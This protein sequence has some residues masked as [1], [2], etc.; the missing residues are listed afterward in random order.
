V[1]RKHQARISAAQQL[2]ATSHQTRQ[3]QDERRGQTAAQMQRERLSGHILHVQLNAVPAV[4][5]IAGGETG[6][7][8]LWRHRFPLAAC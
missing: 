8:E 7:L 6:D 5:D 1:H 4:G 3:R 2:K